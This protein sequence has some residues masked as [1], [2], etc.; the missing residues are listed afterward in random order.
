MSMSCIKCG[1]LLKHRDSGRC[2]ECGNTY[3]IPSECGVSH[4]SALQRRGFLA[5]VLCGVMIMA[6]GNLYTI[7]F[8]SSDRF[9]DGWDTIG[10]PLSV[11]RRGGFAG[12]EY[13]NYHWMVGDFCI[14]IA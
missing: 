10:W 5:G 1:Y 9:T 6:I 11:W 8:R 2:P 4:V 13:F 14:L 12:R 7:G 3:D